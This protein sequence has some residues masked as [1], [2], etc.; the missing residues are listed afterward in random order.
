M[1]LKIRFLQQIQGG[2]QIEFI[3]NQ[4]EPGIHYV[5]DESLDE[6][7]HLGSDPKELKNLVNDPKHEAQ[8]EAMRAQL[9]KMLKGPR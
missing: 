4:I 8:L 9:A 6:L 3:E 1:M 5:E 7:Y 2:Q